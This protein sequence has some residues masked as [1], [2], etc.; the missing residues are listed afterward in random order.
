[1]TKRDERIRVRTKAALAVM[2]G[3]AVLT[4]SG[5]PNAFARA[6]EVAPSR[7][8][9]SAAAE[10]E[11]DACTQV[12]LTYDEVKGEYRAQNNSSDRWARV[13]ASN[14]AAAASVCL[15]PGKS[16]ALALKSLVGSYHADYAEARCGAQD[17]AE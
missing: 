6:N 10:C 7:S 1:M 14:A 4:L 9:A 17:I 3:L 11:G 15:A 5:Q 8:V 2:M 13:S 12:A 16:G